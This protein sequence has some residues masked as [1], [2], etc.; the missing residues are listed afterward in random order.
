ML[1]RVKS[2]IKDKNNEYE[3]QNSYKQKDMMQY[4]NGSK[5]D[6][7]S[8]NFQPDVLLHQCSSTKVIKQSTELHPKAKRL[9]GSKNSKP[10]F[11][12]CE[13]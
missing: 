2:N 12:D 11:E 7:H 8:A 4:K 10:V 6:L 1:F 9:L 13:C 5:L 3:K